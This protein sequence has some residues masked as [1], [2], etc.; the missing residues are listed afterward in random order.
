MNQSNHIPSLP[1]GVI[2]PALPWQRAL[3]LGADATTWI[4][5]EKLRSVHVSWELGCNTS[6]TLT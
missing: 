5:I 2:H 6:K 1:G 3:S 4:V